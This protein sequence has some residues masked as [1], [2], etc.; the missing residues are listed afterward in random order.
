MN[1]V[2]ARRYE[3]W[4]APAVAVIRVTPP[5]AYRSQAS[6]GL[7][8][9]LIALGVL[10]L[11]ALLCGYFGGNGFSAASPWTYAALAAA[12]PVL[13][14]VVVVLVRGATPAALAVDR[15]GIWLRGQGARAAR[16]VGW[17]RIEAAW[18]RD[19]G[20][21]SPYGQV[22]VRRACL[23]VRTNLGPDR[24]AALTG[25]PYRPDLAGHVLCALSD[26]GAEAG[27]LSAVLARYL[28]TVQ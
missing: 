9:A 18:V 15:R 11:P 8:G 25:A 4:D 3:R 19:V 21:L 22:P 5:P 10:L 1:D 14:L 12:L 16:V 17:D 26:V 6:R 20:P 2:A 27:P 23:V 24:G 13:G 7:G 28:D